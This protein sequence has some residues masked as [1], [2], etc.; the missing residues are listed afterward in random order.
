MFKQRFRFFKRPLPSVSFATSCWEKDWR[1][2][3]LDPDYLR[4]RQIGNHGFPF[5]ERILVIN[6]VSDLE[7]VKEAARKKVEEGVLTRVIVAEEKAEESLSFFRLRRGD[8]RASRDGAYAA[9]AD[10]VYYNA[11]GPLTAIFACESEYL[12]YLTG[13]VRLDDP[14]DWIGKALRRMEKDPFVKVANL[15]WN[16]QYGEAKRESYKKDRDFFTARQGFSDQLF[17]VRR[18]DFRRPMYGEIR[19]DSAHFPRGGVFERRV[20]SYMKNRNWERITFRRGSYT[21]E[22]F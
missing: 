10:W 6:N 17:L 16:G 4:V 9:S 3:L 11:L 22:N 5:A 7:A 21:H 14:V 13:D 19:V 1:Q 15:T 20:F 18:S 2:I 8:F 12:L